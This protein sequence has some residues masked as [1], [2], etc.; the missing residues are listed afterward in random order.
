MP[1]QINP[2]KTAAEC[3]E[4]QK[5][6]YDYY[7]EYMFGGRSLEELR[8]LVARGNDLVAD[9]ENDEVT[10]EALT[11]ML[12]FAEDLPAEESLRV[13]SRAAK[14]LTDGYIND[15]KICRIL[16]DRSILPP[17]LRLKAEEVMEQ[18]L[19]DSANVDVI[20]NCKAIVCTFL[21]ARPFCPFGVLAGPGTAWADWIG[22]NARRS[23]TEPRS[24]KN[25][26]ARCPANTLPP[27]GRVA[28][29]GAANADS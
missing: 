27:S 13:W 28:M 8:N 26:S 11:V 12:Q 14:R 1:E 24:T 5:L 6:M 2:E 25:G 16:E 15:P 20:G 29:V 9:R 4:L 21:P 19:R 22:R 3:H 23:N 17:I 10:F 18:I 7:C